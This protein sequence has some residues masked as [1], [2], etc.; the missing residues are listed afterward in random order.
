[1]SAVDVRACVNELQSLLNGRVGKIYHYPPD[2]LRIKI[3]A[4]GRK[5]LVIEAG[6]R[7]HLTKFARESKSPSSFAMLLRKNL[8]GGRIRR[9]EQHDFDRIVLIEVERKDRKNLLIVELFS[10]GNVILANEDM[11]TIMPLRKFREKKYSFPKR[12]NPADITLKA[13]ASIIEGREIVKIL[14]TKLLGGLYAEEVCLKARI[15]KNR[16]AD[17]LSKEEIA[18]IFDAIKSTF[19]PALRNE[20]KPHIVLSNAEYIDVL[21]IEL[22]IYSDL[23][24]KYFETFNEALDKFYFYH[25][26]KE[27]HREKE[28]PEVLKLRR[29]LEIQLETKSRFE[30]ELRRYRKLGDL[31]YENYT[32]IDKILSAFRQARQKASWDEIAKFVKERSLLLPVEHI[33]PSEN[34]LVIRIAGE[35]VE[36]N[37]SKSLPQIADD[38]YEKAKK[39]K[40]KL[41]G[42]ERAIEKTKQEIGGAD[43]NAK[44]YVKSLRVVRKREWFE[45]FRWFVTS[46]GFLVI[47]GRSA[48]MNEELV[49]KYMESKD[50]FFHTQTPGAPATILKNGLLASQISMFEAA[51]FAA[52]YSSLWKEGKYSGE[53]YYVKPEQ[54]KRAAKHGEYLAR[55]GFYIKG[56]RNYLDVPLSCAIGVELAK[57]RVL[58][59]PPSAIK[60][61]CDYVVEIEIDDKDANTLALEIASK[62]VEIARKDEKHVVRGIATPDE[63]MKFLPPG[64]SRMKM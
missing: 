26:M 55:G 18:R 46:D 61:H 64:K 50:L 20:F 4:G 28:S 48:A 53:V 24:K 12:M 9:I 45:R 47:G 63:I 39:I 40:A 3:Y 62:L 14:A 25:I 17:E 59:G 8:E 30:E 56:K 5:D 27:L 1:M 22:Q 60:K 33:N 15:D 37:L 42:L 57:L 10:K 49:S 52:A 41:E 31:I 13:L 21:P 6:K 54:V 19:S 2:E 44:R 36:L 29:R 34:T 7:I 58:G 23:D 16:R 43:K 11:Q 51:Q 35:A 32:T 38:Y